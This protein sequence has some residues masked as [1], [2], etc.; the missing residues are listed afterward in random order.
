MHAVVTGAS[1]GIGAAIAERF[2]QEGYNLTLV[3]RRGNLLNDLAEKLP[4]KCHLVTADLSDLENCTSWIQGSIEALG[5]IDVLVN[6]AGMQFVG[7]T[8][9]V[10][11][12]NGENTFKI[13]VM[14]PMRLIDAILPD[15][16]AR[17][18]GNIVNISSLSA[19]TPTTYMYHY[20]ASKAAIGAASDTL[21]QEMKEY[22]V[23]VVTV[24]PGPVTTPMA[25]AAQEK[26]N[27]TMTKMIP[28]GTPKEL[29]KLVLKAIQKKQR[30][31][32]YPAVYKMARNFTP[33]S[34]WMTTSFTP[35]PE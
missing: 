32:I 20:S 10:G 2:A 29:A 34:Q 14:A 26:L 21:H 3:A 23:H 24:Y 31:V 18:G 5:K 28:T 35:K 12:E 22:G 30:R 33:L 11:V 1:S 4:V 13:N 9:D 7:P 25:D 6:N 17:R 8:L 19:I 15:M 16:I 27:S